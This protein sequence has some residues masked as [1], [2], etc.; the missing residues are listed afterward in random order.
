M[1]V[2]ICLELFFS[3]EKHL[4]FVQYLVYRCPSIDN[5]YQSLLKD[6]KNSASCSTFY[7]IVNVAALFILERIGQLSNNILCQ[8]FNVEG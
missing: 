7:K 5:I 8:C 3:Y 6:Y 1:F 4:T 2:Q